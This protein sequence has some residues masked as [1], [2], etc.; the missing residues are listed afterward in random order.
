MGCRSPTT[1]WAGSSTRAE[2]SG[3]RRRITRRARKG[4]VPSPPSTDVEV[5]STLSAEII[6][7]LNPL[8]AGAERQPQRPPGCWG[9]RQACTK[10][11]LRPARRAPRPRIPNSAGHEQRRVAPRGHRQWPR[12]CPPRESPL[13]LE[14]RPLDHPIRQRR[15]A[16]ARAGDDRQHHPEVRL[17][18]MRRPGHVRL[19]AANVKVIG[20][21]WIR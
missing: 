15:E 8:P 5:P 21:P 17:Q 13:P 20:A 19:T 3:P 16:H 10:L 1:C 9:R 12:S 11:A 4:L 6:S 2:T 7:Q 14:E 18:P